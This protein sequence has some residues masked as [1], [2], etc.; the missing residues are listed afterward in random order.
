MNLWTCSLLLAAVPAAFAQ[1]AAPRPE[2]AVFHVDAS[3]GQDNAD[4]L[5]PATAWRSLARVN[6]A[7]LIPGDAV[8]FR[9]GGLW[10]GTLR[11]RSGSPERRITY[12]AYGEGELPILQGSSARD[13]AGDWEEVSAGIWAT[14]KPTYTLGRSLLDLRRSEWTHHQENG[15]A[16]TVERAGD[17]TQVR[18]RLTCSASGT[19]SNHLQFWGPTLDAELPPL[20]LLRLRLRC[21]QPF[22]PAGLQIMRRQA[23]WSG[24]RAAAADFCEVGDAWQTVDVI[25][26]GSTA[27]DLA[28]PNLFLGGRLPAGAV[29]E[30]EPIGVWAATADREDDLTVDVGNL[31]FDHGAA[32]GV[33]KWRSE[34]L[35]APGDYLYLGRSQQVFLRADGNPTTRHR[36]IE[37]ALNQHIVSQGGVHDVTYE[38]LALRYGAAHGIGGG[39]TARVTVRDCAISYIGGAH[40]M[41]RPDGTPVRFGNGIEFWNGGADH[42]VEGCRLWEIYDAALTNQGSGEDSRQVNLVYRNNVIWNAEY[43]FEYWNR[44]ATAVTDNILFENNT[45]VDAG[46]GWAHGQRPDPNGAHLMFYQNTAK[47]S[48]FVVRN[49]IFCNSTE[50]CLRLDSDWR[51]GL[52]VDHNLWYQDSQPLVRFLV[53]QYYKADDLE[54]YRQEVGFDAHSAVG[55]PRFVDSAARDYRLAEDSAGRTLAHDGGLVGARQRE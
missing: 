33:K 36:S 48:A 22:R 44:P 37:L 45:C 1:N 54:R 29:F 8:R 53:K 50:V 12:G 26:R 21:S 43:S 51:A 35:K 18:Y 15:A 6:R 20:V 28:S 24:Y 10:R 52:T 16:V 14:R 55:A 11:P 40:Q 5:T 39:G 17:E 2:P 23:P 38:D 4:G 31:I 7:E 30:I 47:T 27:G 19:A 32:C 42:L 9:R 3:H 49:N 46:R 41:T 13:A 25:L 34:D